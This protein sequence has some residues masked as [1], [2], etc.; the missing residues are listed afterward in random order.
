MAL[1]RSFFSEGASGG[2]VEA[3]VKRERE[4]EE[5]NTEF[6]EDIKTKITIPWIK[7]EEQFSP[8]TKKPK[9]TANKYN[10]II[11]DC[12]SVRIGTL[13]RMVSEP[14]IFST[15][16]IQLET[17]GPE[18]D[19]VEKICLKAS[20]LIRCE[21]CNARKLPVLFFQTT[22][23]ECVRLRTQLNMSQ[24]QGAQWYNCSGDQFI[25][26]YI[27]LIF[28][29]GLAMKEQMILDEILS[30]IGR[31]NNLSNFPAKLT[32]EEANIRLTIFNRAVRQREE[33]FNTASQK[34]GTPPSLTKA[35]EL[36]L[37]QNTGRPAAEGV[38]GGSSSEPAKDTTAY[39]RFTDGAICKAEPRST[40]EIFVI[41]DDDDEDMLSAAPERD[42]ERPTQ[43]RAGLQQEEHP[44]STEQL[45]TLPVKELFKMLLIKRMAK[46]DREMVYVERQIR[47][48]DLEIELLEHQL[49]GRKN[50]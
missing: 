2:V 50:K 41:D 21:W 22:P 15:D 14:V 13:R 40:T 28:E 3:T 38:P 33:K 29:N 44:T 20:E 47:K 12:R 17:E 5:P 36:A 4:Q 26:K 25:E 31:T 30:E 23:E 24:E 10:S 11:L 48:A 46:T 27:I 45:N 34:L 6:L 43:S 1:S 16:N 18:R 49:Q 19:T 8:R 39:I 9:F 42:S 35:E 32:F 37:S 7:D